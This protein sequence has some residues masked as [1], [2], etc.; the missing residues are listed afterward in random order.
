MARQRR[1]R[2]VSWGQVCVELTFSL[3]SV[4]VAAVFVAM[5]FLIRA[6]VFTATLTAILVLLVLFV[7]LIVLHIVLLLFKKFKSK[8]PIQKANYS[9]TPSKGRCNST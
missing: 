5:T 3:S 2:L 1:S 4:V 7:I 8:R 6:A 9:F